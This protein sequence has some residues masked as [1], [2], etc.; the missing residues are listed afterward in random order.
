MSHIWENLRTSRW[1]LTLSVSL[2]LAFF[3]FLSLFCR[4]YG[5][6]ITSWRHIKTVWDL[7]RKKQGHLKNRWQIRQEFTLS[8]S[9]S[10]TI[11]GCHLRNAEIQ[12]AGSSSAVLQ[13]QTPEQRTGKTRH[14]A[15]F[16]NA[17]PINEL[18]AK[19]FDTFIACLW[20]VWEMS[21]ACLDASAVLEAVKQNIWMKAAPQK[22][23]HTG[24]TLGRHVF[25][26]LNTLIDN[27]HNIAT[28]ETYWY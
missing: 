9:S 8:W 27:C 23:L 28:L 20:S 17:T 6:T 2:L 1:V 12:C 26:H 4:D 16:I 18:L 3:F 15:P 10:A 11:T 21:L 13:H 14:Y 5:L 7:K 19:L 24:F 22:H 25:H